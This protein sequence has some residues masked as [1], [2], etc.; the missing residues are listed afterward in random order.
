MNSYWQVLRKSTS[1]RFPSKE[2]TKVQPSSKSVKEENKAQMLTKRVTTNGDLVD[3]DKLI[4]QRTSVGKKTQCDNANHGLPG[5]LV[6]VS[7][8][9]RRITDA[10]ASCNSLPSSLANLGKVG[11]F[12]VINLP[13]QMYLS[14][15]SLGG[16]LNIF[17]VINREF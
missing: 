5:N 17:S 11:F 7:Y 14:E 4:K 13:N 10:S 9:N 2:E 15:S 1:K 16:Q 6:K 3:P 12:E 8:N